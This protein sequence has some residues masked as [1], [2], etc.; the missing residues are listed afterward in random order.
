MP[1]IVGTLFRI[2]RKRAVG[3]PFHCVT[4]S[5]IKSTSFIRSSRLWSKAADRDAPG[6]D[7][8]RRHLRGRW[9]NGPVIF[10]SPSRDQAKRFPRLERGIL[11][12]D[13]NP[14]KALAQYA[15]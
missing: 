14:P 9:E 6:A 11:P 2:R 15:L 12:K 8:I 4:I 13:Q 3:R 7:A 10:P 1:E 5:M